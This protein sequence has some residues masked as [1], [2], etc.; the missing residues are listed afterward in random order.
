MKQ[1]NRYIFQDIL[2]F[3]LVTNSVDGVRIDAVPHIYEN[4]KFPDEPVI[5]E[6]DN[7]FSGLKHIFTQDQPET[8]TL[9]QN[10]RTF[11]DN[12]TNNT[13]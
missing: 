4:A 10:F 2:K 11:L 8:F 3:W 5:N 13:G 7:T 1:I 12:V 6:K 9:I